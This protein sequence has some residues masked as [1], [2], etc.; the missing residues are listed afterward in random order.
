[1]T[2]ADF[3]TLGLLVAALIQACAAVFIA[4]LTR[5]LSRAT[6]GYAESAKRQ[7]AAQFRPFL[8]PRTLASGVVP[9]I[10]SA[11]ITSN[12]EFWWLENRGFG[13]ALN[14]ACRVERGLPGATPRVIIDFGET[15]G[16]PI[17]AG[18][19]GPVLGRSREVELTK[20]MSS[21]EQDTVYIEYQA[22]DGSCYQTVAIWRLWHWQWVEQLQLEMFT[23]RVLPDAG[24]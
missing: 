21:G 4:I 7:L 3:L 18:H 15:L 2:A 1:M 5:S 17:A 20:D 8:A 10:H 23:P 6:E 19:C 16:L 9:V 22:V 11:A 14:I 24:L 12:P 13:P